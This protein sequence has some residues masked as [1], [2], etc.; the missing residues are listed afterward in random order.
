MKNCERCGKELQYES[1]KEMSNN[2]LAVIYLNGLSVDLCRDCDRELVNW[3]NFSHDKLKD[4]FMIIVREG[5]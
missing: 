1:F 4:D 3:L 5:T 2:N